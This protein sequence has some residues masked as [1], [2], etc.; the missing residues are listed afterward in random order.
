MEDAVSE[1]RLDEYCGNFDSALTWARNLHGSAYRYGTW[2]TGLVGTNGASQLSSMPCR[3]IWEAI[4]W[5][6]GS[7][8]D[9]IDTSSL[10]DSLPDERLHG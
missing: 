5:I 1:P 9:P 4:P 2:T 8:W 7:P 6:L 10:G 3:I